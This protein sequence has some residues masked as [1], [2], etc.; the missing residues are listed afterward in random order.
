MKP[1]TSWQEKQNCVQNAT[2]LNFSFAVTPV[3]RLVRNSTTKDSVFQ[4]KEHSCSSLL[5]SPIK[6]ELGM[7]ERGSDPRAL[8]GVRK[9]SETHQQLFISHFLRVEQ[10]NWGVDK[11]LQLLS[12]PS[13]AG[14]RSLGD[15]P[16][17]LHPFGQGR[18]QS[19]ATVSPRRVWREGRLRWPI[20]P[21][22]T[23]ELRESY[24]SGQSL[25]TCLFSNV[26]NIKMFQ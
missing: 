22:I 12:S 14:S 25:K 13:S 20:G 4:K 11:T 17:W 1:A 24:N 9:W 26:N 3:P 16:V 7:R 21:K 23:L 18:G 8:S 10:R 5:L 15:N 19:P 6:L 2:G